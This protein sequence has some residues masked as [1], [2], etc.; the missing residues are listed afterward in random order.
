MINKKI[1]MGEI[2]EDIT[3]T[4]IAKFKKAITLS[5]HEA[6]IVYTND[7]Q[8]VE[9]LEVLCG[10]KNIQVYLKLNGSC[11]KITVHE[12]YDYVGDI[13]HIINYTRFNHELQEDDNDSFTVDYDYLNKQIEEYENKFKK[14]E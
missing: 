12:A 5:Q 6:F 9:A 7:P 2:T 8:F 13:Y 11:K 14:L 3:G 4:P 10:E 1:I